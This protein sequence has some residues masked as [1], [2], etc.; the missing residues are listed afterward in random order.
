MIFHYIL[1]YAC[2]E[3]SLRTP[4]SDPRLK[5]S[6]VVQLPELST[7]PRPGA[8]IRHIHQIPSDTWSQESIYILVKTWHTHCPMDALRFTAPSLA[9]PQ[10][11]PTRGHLSSCCK[12]VF[13]DFTCWKWQDMSV[14]NTISMTRARSSLKGQN[15]R[16]D[17]HC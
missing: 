2:P 16:S 11:H 17:Q 4:I 8:Y 6:P 1:E 15:P 3:A 14:A 12:A 5:R 7:N 10:P 13:M 9:S